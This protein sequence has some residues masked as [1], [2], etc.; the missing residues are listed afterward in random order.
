MSDSDVAQ[1]N[2][3]KAMF[4]FLQSINIDK[5]LRSELLRQRIVGIWATIQ[6]SRK[7]R[8]SYIQNRLLSTLSQSR[9]SRYLMLGHGWTT[10]W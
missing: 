3:F 8:G 7:K 10:K 4:P 2:S 5:V 1:R 6:S 9:S